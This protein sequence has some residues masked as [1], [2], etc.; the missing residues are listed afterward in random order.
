M[1][2]KLSPR[3]SVDQLSWTPRSMYYLLWRVLIVWQ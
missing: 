2:L 3:L 1:R